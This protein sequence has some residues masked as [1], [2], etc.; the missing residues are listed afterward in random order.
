M[1][2]RRIRTNTTSRRDSVAPFAGITGRLRDILLEESED[3]KDVSMKKRLEA[4]EDATIR[5]ERMLGR[6]CEALDDS[7]G[8]G[9]SKGKETGR[10]ADLD[11]SGT[12]EIDC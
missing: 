12:A 9:T 5:I 3:D 4:L 8:S 2:A 7:S 1:A 11:V 6:L 10:I